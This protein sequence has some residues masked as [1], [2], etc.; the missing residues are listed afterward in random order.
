MKIVIIGGGPGGYTAAIRFAQEGADVTLVEKQ[1]IGGVCLNKG[2]VPTKLL[3]HAA[4]VKT[5]AE[6]ASEWGIKTS[7]VTLDWK[8][9]QERKDATLGQLRSGVEELLKNAGVTVVNGTAAFESAN[10]IVVTKAD[11]KSENLG[12]DKCVIA[13]GASDV[14]P[15]SMIEDDENVYTG[16][17]L[18]GIRQLP[19]SLIVIGGG[20]VG[21]ELAT[22]LVQ[23]GVK[24]SIV[25]YTPQILNGFDQKQVSVIKNRLESTGVEIHTNCK[26]TSISDAW[27]SKCVAYEQEGDSKEMEAE[28]VLMS[29]GR[30]PNTDGLCLD[31]A[32]IEVENNRIKT[33]GNMQTTAKDVYAIGDCASKIQLEYVATNEAE[34]LVEYVM[35][36]KEMH[37]AMIP[38]CV[39]TAPE[40]ARVGVSEAIESVMTAEFPFAASGR[41]LSCGC[42]EG[43][44]KL[45]ADKESHKLVGASIV[46]QSATELIN[47][48]TMAIRTGMTLEDVSETV[49]P[50]PVLAEGIKEAAMMMLGTS[51]NYPPLTR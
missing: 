40:I 12:F 37:E 28:A 36:G 25:E 51:V 8:K 41:A 47:I 46:G 23:M 20:V 30:K 11:G 2:C 1:E 26:V 49:F 24:V 32:G 19:E 33:D 35:K 7:N 17:E 21:C 4:A 10:S 22:A 31:K 16:T 34:Q 50:H 27:G 6:K 43:S 45:F 5:E 3:L 9:V 48:C 13:T 18:L 38:A 44:V 14:K 39:Y 42:T 29:M 15:A